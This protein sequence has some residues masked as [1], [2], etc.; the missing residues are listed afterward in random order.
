MGSTSQD[1]KLFRF[2][3][4]IFVK[5]I[6]ILYLTT[7]SVN[8][9]IMR[10]QV[11]AYVNYLATTEPHFNIS[12]LTYENDESRIFPSKD[13]HII[14]R[15]NGHFMNIINQIVF[16]INHGMNYKIIHVRSYPPMFAALISKW[17]YGVKVV[18]DPRGL[19]PDE[20]YYKNSNTAVYKILK[21]CVKIFVKY[22]DSIVTVS[23]AFRTYYLDK[24]NVVPNKIVSIST[25]SK[26]SENRMSSE[27]EKTQPAAERIIS[28]VYVGSDDKWQMFSEILDFFS[29]LHV[30]DPQ[31]FKFSIITNNLDSVSAAIE[32]M[33]MSSNIYVTS[34]K[35]DAVYSIISKC[36]YGIIFRDDN[37]LNRVAAPIKIVDYL[38][39]GLNIIATKNIGDMSDY[40][41]TNEVGHVINKLDHYHYDL[42]YHYMIE[43]DG[44]KKSK[45]EISAYADSHF[46]HNKLLK[47]YT[48][49]YW[50]LITE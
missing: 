42:A 25:F 20:V 35:P 37:I 15:N 19:F 39:A 43:D 10:T 12:L 27:D 9:P 49:V 38:F 24:Y 41:V 16:V 40:I 47:K 45:S 32:A 28:I 46:S 11:V 21:Y 29:Y 6:P 48:S 1:K 18:F 22:S 50:G 4:R 17:L 13:S 2:E 3:K 14:Y 33:G 30:K 5:N 36:D 23:D 31:K 34:V 26:S 7:E 8:S 44:A